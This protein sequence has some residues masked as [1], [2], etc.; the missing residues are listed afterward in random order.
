MHTTLHRSLAIMLT[1]LGISA[2]AAEA[3][4]RL[5]D[6]PAGKLWV[7]IRGNAPGRPLVVVNGGPGFDHGYL[8]TSPAWDEI[9]KGRRVVMY[10]QRGTGK[11]TPV[12]RAR[13]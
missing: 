1:L 2:A 3:P 13:R 12:N 8:V 10:D 6:G 11:S 7:E 5:I 9:A 4:G